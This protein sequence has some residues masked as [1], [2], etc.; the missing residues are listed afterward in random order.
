MELVRSL[1]KKNEPA[2]V[3]LSVIMAIVLATCSPH[4][5]DV[6]NFDSIQTSIAPSGIIAL[7]MMILLITG[8]FD[9]SVGSMMSLGGEVAA[10]FMTQG[11]P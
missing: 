11:F 10:I 8:S 2:A 6:Y 5:I 3:G 9:L 1:L 7:G 4:F